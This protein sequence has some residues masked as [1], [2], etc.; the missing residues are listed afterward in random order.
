MFTPFPLNGGGYSRHGFGFV[1]ADRDGHKF[2]SH[3]GSHTGI[4]TFIALLPDD[5]IFVT[6]LTNRSVRERRARD[7]VMAIIDILLEKPG[8][9]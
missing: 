6:V 7:D 3:G 9:W 5:G 4:S 2:I 1:V 8:C